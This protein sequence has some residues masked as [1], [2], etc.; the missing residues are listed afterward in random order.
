MQVLNK[1]KNINK[2]VH[3][4]KLALS[5][6][7]CQQGFIVL[8]PKADGEYT[9]LKFDNYVFQCEYIKDKDIYMIFDT[10]S[11]PSK[12]NDNIINRSKWIRKLHPYA[13]KLSIDKVNDILEL[14]DYI[15]KDTALLN[16]YLTNTTDNIKWYPK[17]T[18][19]I[20]MKLYDLLKTLDSNF[21]SLLSYKTDGWVISSLKTIG[22]LSAL[23]YKY[24]PYN[25]L[26]IDIIFLDGKWRSK[27]KVL[28]N[29]LNT[30]NLEI[31]NNTIWR[32]YWNNGNWIP[33]EQRYD[34]KVPNK[35]HI[36]NNLEVFHK[37]PW[38]ATDL[39]SVISNYYYNTE[40]ELNIN[41]DVKEYLDFQ[42]TFFSE[43][44]FTIIKNNTVNNILDLGCGKGYIAN[45]LVNKH[46]TGIDI[47]PINIFI[48]KNRLWKNNF[49]WVC[50]DINN[51]NFGN[52]ETY[53]LIILN[54]TIHTIDN[55]ENYFK[56]L[57]KITHTKS[58][59]YLHF[60]DRNLIDQNNIEFIKPLGNNIYEFKYPWR[61]DIL[62]EK[63]VSFED[64]DK[65]LSNDWK[66]EYQHNFTNTHISFDKLLSS[67]QYL[68]Y[69][70]K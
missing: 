28:D 68:V 1:Y 36:V 41:N 51:L 61:K 13:A 58:I 17:M 65:C 40:V 38:T 48:T 19:L 21:D 9:E 31:Q 24:K 11:Y 66:L 44:I 2:P 30:N 29:V 69:Y 49:N 16:E 57:N 22:K 4:D 5:W 46:V 14:N 54:N 8:S 43:L 26:T 45:L 37:N 59:L 70:K 6:I 35:Q 63:L 25:E 34:K 52:N 47:D 15:I 67:H 20:N 33:R 56:E 27:E 42:R 53:D 39:N 3:I 50:D 55:V 64:I 7:A 18:F 62:T 23:T 60:I 10:K 12:H 32:C